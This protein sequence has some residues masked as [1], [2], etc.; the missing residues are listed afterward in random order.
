MYSIGNKRIFFRSVRPYDEILDAE[1]SQ[2]PKREND[3]EQNI[4]ERQHV[5]IRSWDLLLRD[6]LRRLAPGQPFSP[7]RHH[8]LSDMGMRHTTHAP[9][10]IGDHNET[11]NRFPPEVDLEIK[12]GFPPRQ[13]GSITGLSGSAFLKRPSKFLFG[14]FGEKEH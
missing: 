7:E 13:S 4:I 1:Q 5:A 14:D 2:R 9:N 12:E 11:L 10:I 6:V 8:K 3:L